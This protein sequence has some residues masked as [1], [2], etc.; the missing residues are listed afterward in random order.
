V[1]AWIDEAYARL[2]DNTDGE[3]SR[4]YPAL[5]AVPPDLFG[6]SVVGAG[7]DGYAVGD[8]EHEERDRGVVHAGVS[9]GARAIRG[10][11]GCRAGTRRR[12]TA[13]T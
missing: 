1:E 3:V 2:R 6:I 13:S 10:R 7:G 9:L 5:A 8:A 12:R 4:V 11:A